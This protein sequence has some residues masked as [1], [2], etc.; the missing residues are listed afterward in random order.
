MSSITGVNS[1]IAALKRSVAQRRVSEIVN[2]LANEGADYARGIYGMAD[3]DGN[4]DVNVSVK[5]I[6]GGKSVVASG[7]SVLFME[8][9]SGLIGYGHQEPLQYGPS[10]WSLGPQG[11]GPWDN[12]NVWYIPG[13]RQHTYGNPPAM[14]MYEAKK[15]MAQRLPGIIREYL[16]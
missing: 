4:R 10:T 16:K 5:G 8:Y 6:P 11:R 15:Q 2:A 1:T 14:A 7:K 12:H 9:G 3:Y 13:T